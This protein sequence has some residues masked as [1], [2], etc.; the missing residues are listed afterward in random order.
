M[1]YVHILQSIPRDSWASRNL[2]LPEVFVLHG[3]A[4]A[5]DRQAAYTDECAD[6]GPEDCS[7]GRC[8]CLRTRRVRHYGTGWPEGTGDGAA[9]S[10]TA[11]NL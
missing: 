11:V 1:T 8:D 10:E 9:G 4:V 2:R 7:A 3:E 5:A 6:F